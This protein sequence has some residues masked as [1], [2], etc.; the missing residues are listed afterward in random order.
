MKPVGLFLLAYTLIDSG[1]QQQSSATQA[2]GPRPTGVDTLFQK[3]LECGKLLA[4]VEGS[5]LGPDIDGKRLAKGVLPLNPVVFY[6]PS[7]NTC[8]Y[9]HA[10]EIS[11]RTLVP[12][13]NKY[14][15]EHVFVEDLLTGRSVEDREFNLLSGEAKAASDFEDEIIRRYGDVARDPPTHF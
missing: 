1:C 14:R 10:Y 2:P 5:E 6:S 13:Y 15:V 12:P 11:G 3:K 4:K 7:L 8:V 9:I